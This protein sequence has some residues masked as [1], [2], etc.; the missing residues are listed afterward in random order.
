MQ[1]YGIRKLYYEVKDDKI[2]AIARRLS[3]GID[4][5]IEWG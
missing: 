5:F 3:G 4:E 2:R 1:P